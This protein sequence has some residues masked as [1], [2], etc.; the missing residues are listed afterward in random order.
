[1]AG[2][3][4]HMI[5][6]FTSLPLAD[7]GK[8]L[9]AGL[10]L[11]GGRGEVK[12][13]L[14]GIGD[15]SW[16]YSLT[17]KRNLTEW[18]GGILLINQSDTIYRIT[19]DGTV[20]KDFI[21]DFGPS[22]LPVKHRLIPYSPEL[23]QVMNQSDYLIGKDQ[24]LGFGPIRLFKAYLKSQLFY[25]YADLSQGTGCYHS[26]IRTREG[27][28]PILFP[29]CVSDQGD[30]VGLLNLDAMVVMR[31]SL[32]EPTNDPNGKILYD[33]LMGILERGIRND[34]PILWIAPIKKEWLTEK[35][36]SK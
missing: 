8:E 33:K 34:R 32:T 28:I 2:I 23:S 10:Y 21:A 27:P 3:S 1:M 6:G 22:R 5:A 11:L 35:N 18:P 12:K 17:V 4:E 16:Y 13:A 24:I 9:G 15:D 29:E 20:V 19:P 26:L 31:E 30:L 14:L 36:V 7:K 25:A